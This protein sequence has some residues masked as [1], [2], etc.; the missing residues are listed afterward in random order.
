MKSIE[1]LITVGEEL[2]KPI[3]YYKTFSGAEEKHIFYIIDNLILYE[4][5]LF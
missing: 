3:L 4:Y 5:I 2:G 1:D